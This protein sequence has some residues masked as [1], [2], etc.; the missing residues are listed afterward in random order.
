ME[1]IF[2]FEYQAL[3][4]VWY[5]EFFEQINNQEVFKEQLF[6]TINQFE[7][8]YSR[9]KSDSLLSQLNK[10]RQAEVND[11]FK[12]LLDIGLHYYQLTAGVFDISQAHQLTEHGYGKPIIATTDFQSRLD[13]IISFDQNRVI[14]AGDRQLDLG[15]IGKGYLVDKLVRSFEQDYGIKKYLI[16]GGGDLRAG[17]IDSSGVGIALEDPWKPGQYLGKILLNSQALAYSSPNKRRWTDQAGQNHTHLI[18]SDGQRMIA[19][20]V[21]AKTALE[22]DIMAT[23]IAVAS[24]IQRQKFIDNFTIDYLIVDSEYHTKHPKVSLFD[25]L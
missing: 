11:E 18:Y 9:F 16:N 21:V 14:L 25:N 7:A 4:T 5:F 24:D 1:A 20:L 17:D 23:S 6:S 10:N 3:G 19:S 8:D 13:Q 22:A 15:G 12:D 2:G